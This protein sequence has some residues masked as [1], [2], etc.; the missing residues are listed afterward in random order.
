[1]FLDKEAYDGLAFQI[2]FHMV[3]LFDGWDEWGSA[4]LAKSWLTMANFCNAGR[5]RPRRDSALIVMGR[6]GAGGRDS[7]GC[8]YSMYWLI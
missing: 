6:G 7:L 8:G 1:M 3:C 4:V 5:D 2:S